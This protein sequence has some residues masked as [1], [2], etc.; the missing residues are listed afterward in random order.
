MTNIA[1]TFD[2]SNDVTKPLLFQSKSAKI[3]EI[4]NEFC[5][6]GHRVIRLLEVNF[7]SYI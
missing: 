1:P 5:N 2:I 6:V 3:I 7:V 4:F